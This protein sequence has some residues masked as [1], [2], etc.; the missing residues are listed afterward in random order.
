MTDDPNLEDDM[1]VDTDDAFDSGDDAPFEGDGEMEAAID[2]RAI[3]AEAE[4]DRMHRKAYW[5]SNQKQ[6]FAFLF[7]N[8]L[9]FASGF[10]AWSRPLYEMVDGQWAVTML[11][12]PSFVTGLD[13]IRGALIFALSLYGFWTAVF[14][15]WHAQMKVWPYLMAGMLSL[16][17]GI[18][19]FM[20]GVGGEQW[21][22]AKAYLDSGQ[23]GSKS[24]FD[25]LT[26][27]LGVVAPGY[28]L[29]T[30]GGLLVVWIVINGLMQGSASAKAAKAEE[31]PSGRRRKR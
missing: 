4:L 17:V 22:N 2:T 12:G 27:P 6:L 18:G 13:S 10:A 30:L 19:G 11:D 1:P 5:H 26:V 23:F 21:D 16:W 3:L 15:I 31:A 8:C 29:L 7:A 25:D 28:W 14:N 9:F 24:L 20:A